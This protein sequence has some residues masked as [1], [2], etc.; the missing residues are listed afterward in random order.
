MSRIREHSRP[1]VS[2]DCDTLVQLHLMTVKH[3]YIDLSK[4]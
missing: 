2:F 3:F 1:S 4:H